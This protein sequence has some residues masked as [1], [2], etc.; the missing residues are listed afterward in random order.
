M[1]KCMRFLFVMLFAFFFIQGLSA[2]VV[3]DKKIE[4]S[5]S[6]SYWSIKYKDAD[7]SASAFNL[8]LR[9][10][11]YLFKGL[12]IEPELFLTI[13]DESEDTGYL[14]IGNLAYNFRTSEKL[15]LFVLGGAGYGNGQRI[16]SWIWDLDT[17][18]TVLNFGAG[19]K[20]LISDSA[21]LRIEY[22]FSQYSGEKTETSWWGTYTEEHD[23]TD[24]N[25][26]LGLSVFF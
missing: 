1:K 25:I 8:A 15:I 18:I 20:H 7:D 13:P 6:A 11:Y 16:F 4:L 24:H 5:T 21:A 12:Q 9:F 14:F 26:L 22:R 3:K 23:R 2:Q 17:G 10:G 19:M